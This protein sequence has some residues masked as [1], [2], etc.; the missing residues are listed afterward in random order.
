[1]RLFS[2]PRSLL[3]GALTAQQAEEHGLRTLPIFCLFWEGNTKERKAVD[4]TGSVKQA[5]SSKQNQVPKEPR[6]SRLGTIQSSGRRAGSWTDGMDWH[7]QNFWFRT[8]QS[9]HPGLFDFFFLVG[10]L[11]FLFLP[12]QFLLRDW[13][14]WLTW[15]GDIKLK[16]VLVFYFHFIFFIDLFFQHAVCRLLCPQ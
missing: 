2:L 16:N 14:Y 1:M 11:V 10:W 12:K 3:Q 7:P 5:R 13:L 9:K 8:S 15:P 4:R 6:V